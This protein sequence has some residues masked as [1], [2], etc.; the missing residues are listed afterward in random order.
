MSVQGSGFEPLFGNFF[1]NIFSKSV[2]L[3]LGETTFENMNL[4][5]VTIL[6]SV[7][8]G[9]MVGIVKSDQK[10]QNC[11]SLTVA[12]RLEIIKMKKSMSVLAGGKEHGKAT[13]TVSES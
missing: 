12:N 11:P 4:R 13:Q 2:S 7:L 1:F 6:V 3:L 8:H 10:L 5:K 9:R